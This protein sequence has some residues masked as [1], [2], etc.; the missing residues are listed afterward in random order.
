M[1]Q[2]LFL[3]NSHPLV[4]LTLINLQQLWYLP[5]IRLSLNITWEPG[6]QVPREFAALVVGWLQRLQLTTSHKKICLTGLKFVSRQSNWLITANFRTQIQEVD[7]GK[8]FFDWLQRL[9]LTTAHKKHACSVWNGH[10][11][12]GHKTTRYFKPYEK[13]TAFLSSVMKSQIVS[14]SHR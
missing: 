10:E 2:E 13:F 12:A 9:Q 7:Q 1:S 11:G 3:V 8:Y 5:K 6:S 4:K 14:S